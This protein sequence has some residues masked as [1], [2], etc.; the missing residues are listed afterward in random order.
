M[1]DD[2]REIDQAILAFFIDARTP[3][4]DAYPPESGVRIGPPA[5]VD[6]SRSRTR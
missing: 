2:M 6:E 4:L 3:A 1:L 5:R